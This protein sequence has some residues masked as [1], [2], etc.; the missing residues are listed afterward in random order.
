[1]EIV[2]SDNT[3]T[4]IFVELYEEIL[5]QDSKW[6]QQNHPSVDPLLLERGALRMSEEYEIP[7]ETRAKQMCETTAISGTVTWGHIALE[8]FAE[9]I[10][11][12]SDQDRRKELVQ[13]AA[14][15]VQWITCIDRRSGKAELQNKVDQIVA[16]DDSVD[17]DPEVYELQER[18]NR[19]TV[20][21][22]DL[23]GW[24]EMQHTL[25]R[26]R[27]N[28]PADYVAQLDRAFQNQTTAVWNEAQEFI[29]HKE[30]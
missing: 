26:A 18:L 15:V 24:R 10:C 28:E 19:A 12:Q 13:L 8:E 16:N 25:H 1:M 23:I 14:V 21:I 17:V 20:V 6:G 3:R 4:R 27:G 22:K 9:C 7:S 30:N 5:K 29:D 11:A 2:K